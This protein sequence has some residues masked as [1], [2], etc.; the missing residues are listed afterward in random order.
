V[1]CAF[2]DSYLIASEAQRLNHKASLAI[3][4][5]VLFRADITLTKRDEKKTSD[6]EFN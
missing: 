5:Y 1:P 6:E 3:T 4:L 2:I